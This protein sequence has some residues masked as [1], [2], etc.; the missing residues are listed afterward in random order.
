[1]KKNKNFDSS[2]SKIDSTFEALLQDLPSDLS[3][4][5]K[6]CG[7]FCRERK[8]KNVPQ[9]L[10]VV[11][12]YAGLD[13]SLRETAGVLT[14]LGTKIS[15][16]AV[17]ERLDGC[18]VWLSL[19][20]QKMLPSLPVEMEARIGRRWLL[21]DGST[22]QVPGAKGTSYRIHLSWDWVKQEIVEIQIT[23]NKTGES[24]KLYQI[25][26][27][28]IVTADRG[29]CR[30][31]DC[32]Y[33]LNRAGEIVI[34]YAPHQLTL[35]DEEGEQFNLAGELWETEANLYTRRVRMKR[36]PEERE[37]Y[38]HCYR[39][40]P[41]KAAAARRKKKAK[42]KHDKRVL[43]K[44]TLEYAEW[45]MVLTS[46]PPTEISAEE[47]GK[48]YR[49]RWQIEIVIKRLKSVIEID[50]LRSKIK[51]QLSEVYLLGKSIYALLIAKRAGK[52]KEIKEI[53]WRVWKLMR[54]QLRPLI[55]QVRNWKEEYVEQAKQQL[56]ERKR[57]R[58]RQLEMAQALLSV[59][60]SNT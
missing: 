60:M 45:T 3:D 21:I 2:L 51:S 25:E 5:A 41:E 59:V 16:Q 47:I 1:M 33:V 53:E 37:L 15:D 32:Q 42:A 11:L 20:L 26:A 39:L 44:E 36:D 55:T 29:Y 6:E 8:I 40:P 38:L 7:A 14:L 24:L 27:G 18:R 19:V 57:R 28:D 13:F 34:R 22:V 52:F 49:L 46:F 58:K 23:D 4:L 35:V 31:E 9:L 43:R 50:H 10:Q 30:F 56:K 54:E 48:M 12:L 17:K